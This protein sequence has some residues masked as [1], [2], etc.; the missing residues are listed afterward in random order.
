MSNIKINQRILE[1]IAEHSGGDEVIERFLID[2]VYEEA[3]HTGQW[4]WKS[5]YKRLVDRYS[6]AWEASDED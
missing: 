3:E 6:A 4:W 1:G 5:E 2:L